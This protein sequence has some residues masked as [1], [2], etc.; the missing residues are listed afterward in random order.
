[1]KTYIALFRSINVGGKNSLKMKDLISYLKNFGLHNIKTYIQSGNVVFSSFEEISPTLSQEI[2][3]IILEKHGFSPH[4][5]IL[6]VNQFEKIISKNPFLNEQ[7]Q[8][9][10]IYFLFEK[11]DVSKLFELDKIKKES[12]QFLLCDNAFYLYAPDGIGRSK[13][14][15]NVTKLLGVSATARNWRTICKISDIIENTH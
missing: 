3:A 5:L 9:N 7:D 12:E 8:K 10:H 2:S 4:V 11:P 1:M 13:L 6:T 15:T 14:A